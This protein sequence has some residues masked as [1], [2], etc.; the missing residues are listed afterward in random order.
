[1]Y[2]E[3]SASGNRRDFVEPEW[4]FLFFESGCISVKHANRIH[5]YISL[6]QKRL[7]FRLR[8]PA[9]VVTTIG[10]HDHRLSSVTRVPQFSNAEIHTI[11]QRG[12]AVRLKQ[13]HRS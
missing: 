4:S 9:V 2:R 8:V 5:L 10:N 3:H 6:F 1:M 11:P 13:V 7:Q 12:S